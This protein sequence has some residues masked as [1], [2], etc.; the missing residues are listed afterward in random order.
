[1]LHTSCTTVKT[2]SHSTAIFRCYTTR[3]SICVSSPLGFSTHFADFPSPLDCSA[4]SFELIDLDR[5]NHNNVSHKNLWL[6]SFILCLFRII[7][8]PRPT[9]A[10]YRDMD[11][12]RRHFVV[13]SAQKNLRIVDLWAEILG[14]FLTEQPIKDFIHLMNHIIHA[15]SLRK[16]NRHKWW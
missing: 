13:F 4:S 9:H 8:S 7:F 6:N 15:P 3:W 16:I 5:I 10:G 2:L 11:V 1:M 14:W 12:M